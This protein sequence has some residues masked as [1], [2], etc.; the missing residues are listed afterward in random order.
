MAKGLSRSE[1]LSLAR[2]GA[3]ARI[4]D[5]VVG[6]TPHQNLAQHSAKGLVVRY[7]IEDV[8]PRN[9]IAPFRNW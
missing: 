7:D 1:L 5:F 9:T 8:E 3:E 2:T 6:P 4:A